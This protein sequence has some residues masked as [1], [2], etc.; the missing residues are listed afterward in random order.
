MQQ[1]SSEARS[2]SRATLAA[3]VAALPRASLAA[4]RGGCELRVRAV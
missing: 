2:R 4:F 1:M 3:L